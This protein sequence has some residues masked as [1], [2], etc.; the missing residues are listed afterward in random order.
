M[1]L[2]SNLGSKMINKKDI[3]TI[4]CVENKINHCFQENLVTYIES[5][6]R[7]NKNYFNDFYLCNIIQP[8]NYDINNKTKSLIDA[9]G[10]KFNKVLMQDMQEDIKENYTIILKVIEYCRKNTSSKYILWHDLDV[11]VLDSF[12]DIDL[13]SNKIMINIMPNE[14]KQDY[15]EDFDYLYQNFKEHLSDK[16]RVDN[17]SKRLNTWFVLGERKNK[18]WDNWLELTKELVIINREYITKDNITIETLCEELAAS[19]LYEQSPN[20][21]QE[22]PNNISLYEYD[23]KLSPQIIHYCTYGELLE[24]FDDDIVA[25]VFKDI[26]LQSLAFKKDIEKH[27]IKTIKDIISNQSNQSK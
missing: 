27:E 4:Q 19:I 10:L 5:G 8:S 13:H 17:V 20:S 26:N 6:L 3:T 22:L 18:F 16:Y 11:I 12:N 2:I 21:F 15:H 7:I 23:N 25:L 9:S 1:L 24:H 14:N